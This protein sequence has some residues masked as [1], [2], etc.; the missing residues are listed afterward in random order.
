MV[1]TSLSTC[2]QVGRSRRQ[3]RLAL[4]QDSAGLYSC[5]RTA[6]FEPSCAHFEIAHV[7]GR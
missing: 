2:M 5:R 7:P 1:R 3:N 4:L 6:A